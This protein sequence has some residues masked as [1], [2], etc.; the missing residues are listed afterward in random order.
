MEIK[1]YR[2]V[3]V[4]S[5]Y[6]KVLNITSVAKFY[7]YLT[8]FLSSSFTNYNFMWLTS[9][10][11]SLTIYTTTTG[12]DNLLNANYVAYNDDSKDYFFFIKSASVGNAN[13]ITYQLVLDA[14]STYISQSL[15]TNNPNLFIKRA[16]T[17]R[18]LASGDIDLSAN[19][20]L[21][22]MEEI[23]SSIRQRQVRKD[24]VLNNGYYDSFL[25][26]QVLDNATDKNRTLT[27]SDSALTL[28]YR[29]FIAPFTTKNLTFDATSYAY[30]SATLYSYFNKDPSWGKVAGVYVVRADLFGGYSG[31]G[32]GDFD[33]KTTLPNG[34]I[35]YGELIEGV[36]CI[37]L[38][39]MPYGY[40]ENVSNNLLNSQDIF[41]KPSSFTALSLYDKSQE[42]KLLKN[43]YS[44]FRINDVLNHCK[45]F[46][47]FDLVT[48]LN[49]SSVVT[50]THT[51]NWGNG[52]V[53]EYLGLKT[54]NGIYNKL[55]TATEDLGNNYNRPMSLP[56][57]NDSYLTWLQSSAVGVNTSNALK[58]E[59]GLFSTA[60]GGVMI[61]A[62]LAAT[63]SGVGAGAGVPMLI[64]GLSAIG[65]G[66]I[67]SAG[68]IATP[69]IAE[70]EA[71]T[72]DDSL[73]ASSNALY[74][75]QCPN[76]TTYLEFMG[77]TDEQYRNIA[78]YFYYFGY[79]VNH[80]KAWSDLFTRNMFNYIKT[81]DTNILSSVNA[82]NDV[83][84]M[85][86]TILTNG[87]EIWDLDFLLD[88]SKSITES[89]GKYANFEKIL[90]N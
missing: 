58:L 89:R 32:I 25:V 21:L 90:L 10:S 57:N 28:P 24:I 62:G 34:S 73:T 37:A 45:E 27:A 65:G 41:T 63:A 83:K 17:N 64:G 7:Q 61:S 43:P 88:N 39:K 13:T 86:L 42:P 30:N 56:I 79:S 52:S 23:D 77:L 29:T 67:S 81:G 78:D 85:A 22:N 82:S 6:S 9:T 71:K 1:V 59:G 11:A 4:D 66:V 33:N 68:A 51:I 15:N 38:Y 53:Q 8:R 49:T 36:L 44:G 40:N 72:K 3:E 54:N 19:M 76:S 80:I 50:F 18:Y 12:F 31:H 75:I 26:I 60:V 69:L 48:T 74:Y 20:E 2:G 16:H 14:W 47:P 35:V 55:G 70:N 84:D 5:H 87:V 46:N